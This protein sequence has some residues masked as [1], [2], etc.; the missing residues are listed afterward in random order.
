VGRHLG[1]RNGIQRLEAE[2]V[3]LLKGRVRHRVCRHAAWPWSQLAFDGPGKL[4]L[5][6]LIDGASERLGNAPAAPWGPGGGGTPG[7]VRDI[8]F[9][10]C[11]GKCA[12]QCETRDSLCV[13][14][15]VYGLKFSRQVVASCGKELGGYRIY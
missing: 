4:I 5:Y 12:L 10:H 9:V 2:R 15:P 3:E 14:W 8:V 11:K 7:R 13:S 1:A 6:T